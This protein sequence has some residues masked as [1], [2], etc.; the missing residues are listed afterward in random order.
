[1]SGRGMA[2]TKAVVTH[3]CTYMPKHSY[4]DTQMQAYLLSAF[5]RLIHP[6]NMDHIHKL[7]YPLAALG[8]HVTVFTASRNEERPQQFSLVG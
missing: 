8:R 1:M 2:L 3:A 7:I 5:Q 6:D 4:V